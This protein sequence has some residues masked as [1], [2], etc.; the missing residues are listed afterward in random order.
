MHGTNLRE[1]VSRGFLLS[2]KR[3]SLISM[4]AED[5]SYPYS[6]KGAF[7]CVPLKKDFLLTEFHC[8]CQAH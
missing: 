5:F 1:C 8:T 2:V 3:V 4:L 7:S 6:I